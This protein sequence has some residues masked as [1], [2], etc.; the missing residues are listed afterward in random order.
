M[1]NIIIFCL[2]TILLVYANDIPNFEFGNNVKYIISDTHYPP[3]PPHDEIARM[4][5]YVVHYSDWC[6]LSQI[7]RQPN[8]TGMPL[9]RV[10]SVSDG[11]INNGTGVPYIYC[12]FFDPV[13]KDLMIDNRCSITVTLAEKYCNEKQLDPEDPRCAQVVLTGRFIFIQNNTKEWEFAKKALFTRHPSMKQWPQDH[14]FR[15]G[16]LAINH[17]KVVDY[18]GGSKY[19]SVKDYFNAKPFQ[20]AIHTVTVVTD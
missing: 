12:S 5:R 3:P 9:G 17:I 15:F 19:P 4:A 6:V 8:T 2:S 14:H 1:K 20:R 18:F 7:S 16:Q 11:P 10:F 13:V